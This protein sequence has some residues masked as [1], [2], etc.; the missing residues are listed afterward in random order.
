MKTALT[1]DVIVNHLVCGIRQNSNCLT[2]NLVSSDHMVDLFHFVD[3]DQK[4]I[5]PNELNIFLKIK[6]KRTNRILNYFN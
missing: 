2:K 5:F 1:N 6:I 3:K 4:I